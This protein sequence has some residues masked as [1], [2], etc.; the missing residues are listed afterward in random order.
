MIQLFLF[1]LTFVV[2]GDNRD[3]KPVIQPEIFSQIIK[4][5]NIL[6][7]DLVFDSGDLIRGYTDDTTL[8]NKE[9]GVFDSVIGRLKKP[10]Y[11]VVGNHDVWNTISEQIFKKR[12]GYLYKSFIKDNCLFIILD[13]ELRSDPDKIRGLQLN[14]LKKQL[15]RKARFKFLFLHKPLWSM[16][17]T[18][19]FKTIQ[20]ILV[21]N[22]VDCV[23]CGHWHAYEL[24]IRD[25][26]R[27]IIT[28]GAGAPLNDYEKA[29]GFYHYLLVKVEDS[30]RIAVIRP[31]SVFPEDIVLYDDAERIYQISNRYIGFPWTR[32]PVKDNLVSL[33]FTNPY[34]FD[35]FGTVN[36]ETTSIPFRIARD[37]TAEVQFPVPRLRGIVWYPTPEVSI[38][39]NYNDEGDTIF[40][41]RRIAIVP[42]IAIKKRKIKVDGDLKEWG[43]RGFINLDKGY[44]W[45]SRSNNFWAGREDLS[46]RLGFAYDDENFYFSA[47]VTDD[48]LDQ[49]NHGAA[50]P[51]GDCYILTV[52]SYSDP[53]RNESGEDL[54]MLFFGLT[55]KGP[56]G[57]LSYPQGKG[58]VD[59]HI[60]VRRTGNKTVYEGSI[61]KKAIKHHKWSKGEV[62]NLDAIIT[63]SDGDKREGWISLTPAMMIENNTAF[64]YEARLD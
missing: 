34:P 12:Y 23:F 29:G 52:S 60:E 4:E 50:M 39:I 25:G 58:K 46:A 41:K 64:C 5:I 10:Y 31:N 51:R 1:S 47:I 2:M 3:A 27:Y 57:Y 59:Y 14:W 20:P 37:E 32:F 54:K 55:E 36:I 9:W 17:S 6:D 48:S 30:V 11:L 43:N 18:Y 35:L 7:P 19:W 62:L 49:R 28:G 26:I 16:D 13:T 45:G 63:D 44:Y 24:T 42:E 38:V 21:K 53:R 61:S 56:S 40:V 33:S 22:N 8:I 15:K